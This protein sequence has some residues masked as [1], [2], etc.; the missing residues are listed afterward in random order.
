V[1]KFFA[2]YPDLVAFQKA[3]NSLDRIAV[4]TWAT[5][6]RILLLARAACCEGRLRVSPVVMED[7]R[8][9]RSATHCLI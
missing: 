4:A 8:T 3:A 9:P 1:S 5:G 7:N 2:P 6:P